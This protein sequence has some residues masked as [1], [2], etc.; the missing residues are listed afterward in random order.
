MGTMI[1]ECDKGEVRSKRLLRGVL[2]AIIGILIIL[3]LIKLGSGIGSLVIF[4]IKKVQIYGNV[5]MTKREVLQI[6]NLDASNSMITFNKKKAKRLILQD[7]RVVSI[8]MVKLYPDTLRIYIKEKLKEAVLVA[9]S[10]TYWVSDDGI[11]LSK[12]NETEDIKYSDLNYP[13]IT[14]KSYN[15]DIKSGEEI[16]NFIVIDIINSLISIKEEYSDFY[17]LIRSF[18]IQED[19]VYVILK[20]NNYLIYFGSDVT[21]VKLEKLR[22]LLIVLKGL[23][24]T[25]DI[26]EIDMSGSHAAVKKREISNEL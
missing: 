24:Q 18:S 7:K 25:E 10:N 16:N 14:L 2:I 6:M 8:E 9:N 21:K 26:L 22:A 23:Y 20:N 15:D 1:N 3:L 17:G 12:F 11:I 5:H 13:Y 4:P 19:G